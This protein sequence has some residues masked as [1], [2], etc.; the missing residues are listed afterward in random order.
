MPAASE[1]YSDK[2]AATEASPAQA[3]PEKAST[4]QGEAGGGRGLGR[5]L[6]YFGTMVVGQGMSFLLLPFITRALSPDEYGVYTIALTVGSLVAMIASS[7]LRN[8]ALR[9]YFDEDVQGRTRA[10]FVATATLQAL[11]LAILYGGTLL[12]LPSLPVGQAS[13]SV[14][15]SAGL[16]LLVGDLAVYATTL[17]RAEQRVGSFALAEVGGGVVRFAATLI[18]LQIGL[19][20][21][22]L[23]FDATTI[24]YALAALVALV[25]LWP[26]LTGPIALDIGP[27]KRVL[28]HGPS[29]LPF[30]VS[31]WVERLADRL[32]I[33]NYLGTAA[34]GIYSVGYAIGERTIGLI[35]RAVFMMAWP[36]ILV[37]WRDEGVRGA[38]SAIRRAQHLYV[39][40]TV[41]PTVFMMVYG[42][43]LLRVLAGADFRAG[44]G[45]V[46][47]ISLSMWIGGYATYFNRDMELNKRFGAIST[48]RAVGAA[49]NLALNLWLVPLYGLMGA[50][51]A[52]LINRLLNA[53][54]FFALRDRE[55]V[56]VPLQPLA[57]GL[58]CAGVSWGASYMLP[59]MPLV[60]MALFVVIYAPVALIMMRRQPA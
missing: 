51:W 27:M 12:L 48:V 47:L 35:V 18:G 44:D 28:S 33:E 11:L 45:L 24:G 46:P 36:T 37:A 14:Y 43:E 23:L 22:K 6:A 10:F 8:V 21:A 15:I 57:A 52:T 55:L 58:L 42:G 5:S 2:P 34:V 53:G 13:L 3:Q 49:V 54:V 30:S 26:R 40:F 32:V 29:A 39:W 19:N 60:K 7:W 59:S 41:G 50:A 17:L 1:G 16:S 20:S 38:A 56:S 25:A 4:N 9:L 31:D